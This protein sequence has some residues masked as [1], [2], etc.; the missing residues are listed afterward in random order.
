MEGQVRKDDL[1]SVPVGKSRMMKTGG[2][3]GEGWLVLPRNVNG[4][5]SGSLVGLK[6]HY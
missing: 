4:R 6:I 3:G 2:G 5:L 1:W